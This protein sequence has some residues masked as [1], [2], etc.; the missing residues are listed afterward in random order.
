M[1]QMVRTEVKILTIVGGISADF[2][3]QCHLSPD[4][5]NMQERNH[6]AWLH[7]CSELDGRP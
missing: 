5:H 4:D 1:W 7:F 6:S 2:D 3:G